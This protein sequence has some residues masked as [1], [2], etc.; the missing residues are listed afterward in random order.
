MQPGSEAVVTVAS[1]ES[2]RP[3]EAEAVVQPPP[4]ELGEPQ[5]RLGA[6][7]RR[8]DQLYQGPCARARPESEPRERSRPKF[9]RR[10]ARGELITSDVEGEERGGG[11]GVAR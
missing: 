8:V 5:L 3:D 7:G 9:S 11:G 2:F 1:E 4:L 6:A 10:E